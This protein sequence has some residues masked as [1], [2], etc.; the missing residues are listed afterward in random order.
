MCRSLE[1]IEIEYGPISILKDISELSNLK[2]LKLDYI[3]KNDS[4]NQNI[5][6]FFNTFNLENMKDLAIRYMDI[7]LEQLAILAS[8]DCPKLKHVCLRGCE[9][10]KIDYEILKRMILNF[11]QIKGIHVAFTIIEITDEQ[12]YQLMEQSGVTIGVGFTRGLQ[13]KKYLKYQVPGSC[14]KYSDP[15]LCDFCKL[16]MF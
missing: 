16:N 11:P 15:M 10:L 13:F 12:L 1:K 3:D 9:K 7:S 2:V 14:Q 8:R 6:E 5:R 4:D